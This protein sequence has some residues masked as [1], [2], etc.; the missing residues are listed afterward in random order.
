MIET[1]DLKTT[2]DIDDHVRYVEKAFDLKVDSEMTTRI[3]LHHRLKESFENIGVIYG[4]SGSG[5]SSILRMF[6]TEKQHQFDKEKTLI[7]NFDF[8]PPEDAAQLLSAVGLSSVP[9]L[10]STISSSI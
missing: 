5:K 3:P 8:M 6:G 4:A 1:L 9:S 7:S 2:I 10:G